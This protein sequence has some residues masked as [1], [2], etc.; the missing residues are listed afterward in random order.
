MQQG[1]GAQRRPLLVGVTGGIGSGKSTVVAELVKH[2]A[3]AFSADQAVHNL[4]DHDPAV[5]SAVVERWGNQVAPR[6]HPVDRAAIANIVFKDPSELQWLE[7]LLHPLVAREWLRFVDSIRLQSS[8]PPMLV[9]EVPLLFEAGLQ[10][11]YDITLAVV[12]PETLR[13]ER[14]GQRATGDS[15]VSERLRRQLSDA[16]RAALATYSI[17]NGGTLKE[18]QAAVQDFV[19]DIQSS[20]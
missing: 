17:D 19:A 14:V 20:Q 8:Q 15:H 12:V 18:L 11:R 5:R 4:Y 3:V 7:S 6:G 13:V 1:D 10:D 2:G 9:A 16:D